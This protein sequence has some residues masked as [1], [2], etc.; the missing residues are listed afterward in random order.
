MITR[1]LNKGWSISLSLPVSSNDRTSTE[2]HGGLGTQRHTTHSFGLGDIRFELY[3]WLLKPSVRQRANVQIVLGVKFPTGDY[4][5][6][7]YF[8]RN[9]STKVLAPVE[10]PIQLGDGGTGIVTELN[11]FYN[12]SSSLSLFGNFYYLFN[13]REQNGVLNTFGKTPSDTSLKSGYYIASVPDQYSIRVGI[14]FNFNK[15]SFSAAFRDEGVPVYDLIGGSNGARKAGYNISVEPGLLYKLKKTTLY[16]YL[17]VIVARKIKQNVP[18][19]IWTELRGA[20]VLRH[21]GSPD[22]LVFLGAS[23]KL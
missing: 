7:D 19:K 23:F 11:T 14:N 18:D 2:E 10:V 13:P 8:Y 4:K 22:Y 9:D 21:G 6:Q 17:P 3:K 1:L 16:V 15:L 20:Y 5:Y 12:F